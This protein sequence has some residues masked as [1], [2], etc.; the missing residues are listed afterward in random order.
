MI[1]A[2]SEISWNCYCIGKVM[3]QIYRSRDH[4][5]LLVH[6]GLAT[7][8]RRDRSGA[9]EV[10][11]IAWRERE[12]EGEV[13]GVFTNGATWRWSCG[14]GHTTALNRGSRWC[15]DGEMFLGARK[16]DWSQG[17]CGG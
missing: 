10:I 17:G 4:G 1:L 5:W 16:K 2:F 12:K 13:I 15:S 9:W 7:M 14:D 6:G 3:D 11:V 8:E